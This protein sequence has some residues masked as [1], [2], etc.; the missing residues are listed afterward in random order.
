MYLIILSVAKY[1]IKVVLRLLARRKYVTRNE[2]L[3][4]LD[5]KYE[6]CKQMGIFFFA[7]IPLAVKHNVNP[8]L[9]LGDIISVRLLIE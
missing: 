3:W 2:T 5:F 1:R 8:T 4:T 7:Y 6:Q 9:S